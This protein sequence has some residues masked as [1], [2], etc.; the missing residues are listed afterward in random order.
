MNVYGRSNKK[1]ESS[2]Q[3]KGKGTD[4]D[5]DA[6]VKQSIFRTLKKKNFSC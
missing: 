5:T 1:V 2:I 4:K 6:H 3:E